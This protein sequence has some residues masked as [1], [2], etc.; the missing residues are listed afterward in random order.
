GIV[1]SGES[2]DD[3]GTNNGDGCSSTCMVEP[4]WIC[5]GVPSVCAPFSICG[6]GIIE[7]GESCDDGGTNSGDGCSS[8]CI[9]EPGWMCAGVPSVCAPQFTCGNGIVESGESCDDGGTNNGDGC[10]STCMVEPGWICAGVPSVCVLNIICGNGIIEQGE[11]CDD[12]NNS[13]GDGCNSSCH[14]EGTSLG[15]AINSDGTRPDPSSMLDVKSST[16]GILIPRMTSVQ[17]VTIQNPSNGLLVFD[18]TTGSFWY[19]FNFTWK[20]ISTN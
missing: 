2:C 13:S 15:V 6:N 10:S 8:A 12:G 4:G 18:L 7:S 16:N 1:E 5:A 17:R 14:F 9:V 11:E 19:F 3:G 20:Q